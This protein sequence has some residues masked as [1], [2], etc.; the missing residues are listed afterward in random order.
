MVVI[1]VFAALET[2]TNQE[3][4]VKGILEAH[5]PQLQVVCAR[6]MGSGGLIERENAAILNASVLSMAAETIHGF[7]HAVRELGINCKL[8][9]TQNN[10]SLLSAAEAG[11]LP[12]LTFGS[13]PTV[14]YH[15]VQFC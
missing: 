13:G 5:I 15:I 1:A 7:Q 2:T 11:R 14:R 10:G 3:E 6:D 8:Y 12:I 9:L 4:Q